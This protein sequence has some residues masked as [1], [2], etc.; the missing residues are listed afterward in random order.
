[1]EKNLFNLF[2]RPIEKDTLEDWAK[3]VADVAK[4]SILAIPV[5]LYGN[6]AVPLKTFN[7][8]LLLIGAYAALQSG[9]IIRRYKLK[10]EEKR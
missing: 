9:R 1:M 2:S 3:I 5:V 4:V 6:D 7:S 8:I 10:L